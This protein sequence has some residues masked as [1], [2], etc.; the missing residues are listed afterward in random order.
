MD[1]LLNGLPLPA[2]II[3]MITIIV[4]TL[5]KVRS[6]DKDRFAKEQTE[7]IARLVKE[8][9]EADARA[10]RYLKSRDEEVTKRQEAEAKAAAV[11]IINN[12]FAGQIQD[13]TEQ[14]AFLR[15]EV[16]QLKNG[17]GS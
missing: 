4:V 7:H 11:E 13:L 17:G 6:T 14:V 2:G 5:I 8:R 9:E 15:A 1:E 3:G 16:A 12:R 10:D